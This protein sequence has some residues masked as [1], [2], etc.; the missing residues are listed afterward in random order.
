MYI[1]ESRCI[2]LCYLIICKPSKNQELLFVR[3]KF[4]FLSKLQFADFNENS[5]ELPIGFLVG[6]DCYYQFFTSK[7]I[8]NETGLVASQVSKEGYWVVAFRVQKE[9]LLL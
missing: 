5:T 8:K 3:S 9:V 7:F 6:V 4:G 2:S 1:Y